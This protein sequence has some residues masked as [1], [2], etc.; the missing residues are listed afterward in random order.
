MARK[1]LKCPSCMYSNPLTSKYCQNCGRNFTKEEKEKSYQ[2]TI[3]YK[4]ELVKKWYDHLTLSTITSHPFF[5]ACVI[6]LILGYGSSNLL[7]KGAN[8]AIEK[9][10]N[11]EIVYNNSNKEY[12]L[13]VADDIQKIPVNLYVPS[14]L[15]NLNI[16]HYREDGVLLEKEEYN[17]DKNL[18]LTT[19]D[20]DYFILDATYQNRKEKTAIKVYVH[21]KDKVN[22]ESV[23]NHEKED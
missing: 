17:V 19:Y 21:N 4:L 1:K 15:E 12:Y 10:N 9:D 22:L 16:L 18:F 2:K 7:F 8:V 23:D 6:G 13:L 11:Y 20:E 3:Y 5:R 14:S